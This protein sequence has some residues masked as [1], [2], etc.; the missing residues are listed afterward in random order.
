MKLKA[1]F[2]SCAILVSSAEGAHAA[3]RS[4]ILQGTPWWVYPLLAL[5][6]A[7]GLQGLKSRAVSL[8]RALVVPAIFVS[9]GV[10]S[11][12]L[13]PSWS[14]G[15]LLDWL[16]PASLGAG[17][18]LLTTRRDAAHLDRAS[19]HVHLS[20]SWLPLLRNLLVFAAKYGLAVAAALAPAAR[21]QFALWDIAVSGASA[22][23]F[24]GWTAWLAWNARRE[25]LDRRR[26]RR[27]SPALSSRGGALL[28]LVTRSF[29]P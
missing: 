23:Y 4:G 24:L 20:G 25:P 10:A 17:L 28:P 15:L 21:G 18:A 12:A 7:I 27:H 9:W 26:E 29:T 1:L 8:A 5:L 14:G 16:V 2:V 11:L 13:Q 3:A 6:I 22:G 19:G